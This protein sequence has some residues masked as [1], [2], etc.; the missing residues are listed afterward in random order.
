MLARDFSLPGLEVDDASAVYRTATQKDQ[1]SQLSDQNPEHGD[2][3]GYGLGKE[4]R[5]PAHFQR[6][7]TGRFPHNLKTCPIKDTKKFVTEQTNKK[8][9]CAVSTLTC[10]VSLSKVPSLVYG[11]DKTKSLV[12]LCN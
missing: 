4:L 5:K 9:H 3:Q 10:P 11:L 12:R 8:E 7:E 6:H 2:L 1:L